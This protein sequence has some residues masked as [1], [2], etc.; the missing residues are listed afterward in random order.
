MDK[1]AHISKLLEQI[2]S[3]EGDTFAYD[4]G[5][6]REVYEKQGANTSSLAIKILSIFGGFLAMLAFLGFLTITG[7]YNSPIG[8]FLFGLGFIVSS[9]ALS[10][11]FDKLIIDTFSISL[12]IIGFVLFIMGLFQWDIEENTVTLLTGLLALVVL[13][14]TRNYI[15]LFISV[16]IFNGS[17]LTLIISNDAYNLVHF[18]VAANAIVLTSLLLNEARIIASYKK[19]AKLYNPLRIG[20]IMSI[21]FGLIAIGKK[22]LLPVS[23]DYIW[24]SSIVLILILAYLT[25]IIS[26]IHKIET[27][28]T[29]VIIYSLVGLLLISTLFAPSILG[30][31]MILLLCFL[32]NYKTGMIIGI[33]ALIYFVGQY[34]YDLSFTLLT[35][36][37]I[38]FSS[39]ILFGLLYLFLNRKMKA[40]EKV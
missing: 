40:D 11:A 27:S 3:S 8:L 31:L 10:K 12:Y 24:L 7:L 35:K 1:L 38:L 4:E 23:Q 19:L 2:R 33:I 25:H 21:L 34:Y 29:K 5:K 14:I 22:D 36:S 30:A 18:Y 6:I 13:S 37:I 9:I 28:K 26:G 39:G 16:L 15:L 17:L 32:V 20:L